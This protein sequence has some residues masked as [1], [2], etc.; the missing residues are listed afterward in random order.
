M[1]G[2]LT[3][4]CNQYYHLTGL[5][6]KRKQ[7]LQTFLDNAPLYC[8]QTN[9]TEVDAI[10]K[11]YREAQAIKAKVDKTLADIKATER[12]IVTI[13]RHFDI[14][15]GT[16]LTGQVPDEQEYELWADKNDEVYMMKTKSLQ[17]PPNPDTIVIK[18]WNAG[19]DEEEE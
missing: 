5:L 2:E 15:A 13:M 17:P 8:G 9:L 6:L 18:L 4:Y 7:R 14:P 11:Y 1:T 10:I 3:A 16:I 12:V 19:N